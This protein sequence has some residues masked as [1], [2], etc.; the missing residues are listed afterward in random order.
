MPVDRGH[1]HEIWLSVFP[2]FEAGLFRRMERQ[3]RQDATMRGKL[4]GRGA[5]FTEIRC[6]RMHHAGFLQI[7]FRR[8][9]FRPN[10]NKCGLY[11]KIIII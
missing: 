7:R 2:G 6:D 8:L 5:G 4:P 1:M 9:Y 10:L 3:T 11:Y